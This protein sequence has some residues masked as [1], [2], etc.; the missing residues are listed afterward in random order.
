MDCDYLELSN[1]ILHSTWG[2]RRSY[3]F[4]AKGFQMQIPE[5]DYLD[6]KAGSTTYLCDVMKATQLSES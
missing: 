4:V 3:T 6:F 5:P 2:L 1:S